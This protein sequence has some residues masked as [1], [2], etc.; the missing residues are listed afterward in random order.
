MVPVSRIA[1]EFCS[2]WLSLLSFCLHYYSLYSLLLGLLSFIMANEVKAPPLSPFL[3]LSLSPS[4]PLSLSPSLPLSLSPS[5]PLSPPQKT[6]SLLSLNLLLTLPLPP[7][8]SQVAW[9]MSPSLIHV[10]QRLISTSME[11]MLL[12]L[13]KR[14]GGI[15][16][17]SCQTWLSLRRGERFVGGFLLFS[18][19][20]GEMILFVDL[21]IC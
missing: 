11:L 1:F 7:S 16:C 18:L 2:C 3:P 5:L 15:T 9:N 10:E 6:F 20:L 21:L 12:A 19:S 17:S 13:L 4:L 8:L 14:K